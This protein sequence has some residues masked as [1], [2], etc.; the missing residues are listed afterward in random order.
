MV[1][2]KRSTPS[3]FRRWNRVALAAVLGLGIA[4]CDGLVEGDVA[5]SSTAGNSNSVNE[6]TGTVFGRVVDTNAV[7]V[8]GATVTIGSLTTTTDAGGNWEIPNV[9]V[10]N[11]VNGSVGTAGG[12]AGAGTGQFLTIAISEPGHMTATVTLTPAAQIFEGID[13]SAPG[14]GGNTGDEPGSPN[15]TFVQGYRASTGPIGIPALEERVTGVLRDVNTGAALANRPVS[16]DFRGV[17]YDQTIFDPAAIT[18]AGLAANGITVTL[19]GPPMVATSDANGVFTIASVPEDSCL[20]VDISGGAVTVIG[21]LPGSNTPNPALP[22]LGCPAVGLFPA[23]PPPAANLINTTA[24]GLPATID[25]ATVG[26]SLLS[27]TNDTIRPFMVSVND[28]TSFGGAT[29]AGAIARGV[30]DDDVNG[31]SIPLV[32]VFNEPLNTADIDTNSVLVD[33]FNSTIPVSSVTVNGAVVTI[34]LATALQPGPFDVL[35]NVGDFRDLSDNQNG[36]GNTLATGPNTFVGGGGVGTAADPIGF[37]NLLAGAFPGT[38]TPI[39]AGFQ[40]VALTI[41][42]PVNLASAAPT[43]VQSSAANTSANSSLVFSTSSAFLDTADVGSG[44]SFNT[45]E[46]LNSACSDPATGD[47]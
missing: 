46:N 7:G 41:F 14:V 16:L 19:G 13:G 1:T 36:R 25:L 34:T 24:E 37:D 10:V 27:D 31:T 12:G 22:G 2:A 5:N 21:A 18:V 4:G 43:V 28:L 40:G 3:L 45:V 26:V 8:S 17:A 23:A 20:D 42:T 35:L 15:S 38:G 39:P 30:L 32:F 44:T 11:T 9:A 29:P 47:N 6:P 33:Q